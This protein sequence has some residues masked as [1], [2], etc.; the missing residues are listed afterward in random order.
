MR[1]LLWITSICTTAYWLAWFVHRPLVAT[2]V[3]PGY[4]EFVNAFPVAD[5]WYAVCLAA[6]AVSLA[7]RRPVALLWLFAAG[8]AGMFLACIDVLYDI[9]HGIWGR[10]MSGALEFAINV[11]TAAIAVGVLRWGWTRRRALLGS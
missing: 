10:G 8:G 2:D 1:R 3:R 6:A 5:G 7:R 11:A 9:E 4:E